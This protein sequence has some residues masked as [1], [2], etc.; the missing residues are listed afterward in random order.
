MKNIIILIASSLL[1]ACSQPEQNT[2]RLEQPPINPYP[3]DFQKV[4]ETHGGLDNWK[5]MQAL[6][7][8]I[9]RPEGTEMNYINLW[10]RKDRIDGLNFKMGFDGK[11][12][13]MD[14]DTSY[15]G[16]PAFYHNL[17]FYFYAMPFVLA[18]PGIQ[19]KE[20][21][22]LAFEGK[23]YPAIRISFKENIGSSDKDEYILYYDPDTYQMAWLGYTATYFSKE[24]K[25]NFNKIRYNDWGEVNGLML[26]NSVTW[27]KTEEGKP[28]E[29]RNTV[30]FDQAKLQT[31][32][33]PEE[34]FSIQKGAKVVDNSSEDL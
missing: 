19:Y 20:G 25:E 17:M 6:T 32:A 26:P 4:F 7:F 34:L 9:I 29:P 22:P 28:T 27:F 31:E 8:G 3:D 24:R 10:D 14:A 2:S 1:L 15:K 30:K 11:D 21:E 12:I 5:Q 33:H 13:W 23:S 16:N 18:D